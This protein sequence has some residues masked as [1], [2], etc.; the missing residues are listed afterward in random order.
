MAKRN[1]LGIGR[2][3]RNELS[4]RN[5]FENMANVQFNHTKLAFLTYGLVCYMCW[6]FRK[7]NLGKGAKVGLLGLFLSVNIQV[8]LGIYMLLERVPVH[9]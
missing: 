1:Q 2:Y 7:A 5:M 8:L 4:W 9:L 6:R 3:W